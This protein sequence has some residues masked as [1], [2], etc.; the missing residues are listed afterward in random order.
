MAKILVTGASGFIGKRLVYQL[1]QEGHTVYALSRVKGFK[2]GL[3]EHPQLRILYGD[4][5]NPLQMDPFPFDLDAAYY[6]VHS[7]GHVVDSLVS[8]EESIARNFVEALAKTC[9]KQVIY[10]G[11][12]VEDEMQLSPHLHSR[13]VVEKVL[14]QGTIPF[15]ILRASIIIGA[16]S[17][18]FEIIRDL[19]EKLPVMVA[20]K[21]VQSF[22]QP[23][24][25][26][27][28]LY[29]LSQVLL[30]APC[31]NQRFDIAGPEA[32]TFRDILLRYA[33][34]RHLKRWILNVPVLTPKLSSYW[35]VFIT[36]VR[37]SICHHLV[38]SMKQN[39]R[40]LNPSIDLIV[41]HE[42]IT[43]EEALQLAFQKISQNE[44][45]STWM[46]AWDL[47]GSSSDLNEIVE[48]PQEGCLKDIRVVPIEVGSAVALDR[49]WK[50][51]G[52][53]GWYS[54]NWAW[55]LR[56]LVDQLIGGA[57]LNRGRRHESEINVG[58]SIDFWRVLL[59]DRKKMHLILLAQMK[60]PGEAWLEFKIDE[61]RG[62]LIQ[63]ATFRPVGLWGRIYWYA[64]L[65][66]HGIIFGNMAQ[67]IAEKRDV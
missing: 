62:V 57:G 3:R 12:I 58:D 49:I 1:L 38:E 15:T 11:G 16:G 61:G 24:S 63:T 14:Q 48:V 46:D 60:L 5:Q 23:I 67:S 50:I 54:M 7:M 39:T 22:C 66:F 35:L 52:D 37:F 19:V 30:N 45:V 55:K 65:P 40:K 10:L 2:A 21:W 27:D 28:V 17:A 32:M 41:P 33:H 13:L 26:R 36:D 42:C 31:L 8:V 18:S 6:L 56:G 43:Y 51:G 25:I 29:Y 59:A 53:A 44:V 9:C 34:F 4:I 64:L 20:P 47:H